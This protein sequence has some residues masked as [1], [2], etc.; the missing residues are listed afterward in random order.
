M[1]EMNTVGKN[2]LSR[3]LFHFVLMTIFMKILESLFPVQNELYVKTLKLNASFL[4]L[5]VKERMDG[6]QFSQSLSR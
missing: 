2:N 5:H 4:L 3:K 6:T 1:S